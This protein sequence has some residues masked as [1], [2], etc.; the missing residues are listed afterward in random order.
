MSK[1]PL[2]SQF[3]A[4]R[5]GKDTT[6]WKL[7]LIC[8]SDDQRKGPLVLQPR[9]DTYKKVLDMVQERARFKDGNYVIVQERLKGIKQDTLREEKALWHRSC[10]SNAT[11][12]DQ[13]HRA[14]DR[15]EH[16]LSTGSFPAKIRGKKRGSSEMDEPGPSTYGQSAPFTRSSTVPLEKGLCFFCQE[17]NVEQLFK[18]CT[19]NAGK[20]LKSA[21]DKSQNAALV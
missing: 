20:D 9:L 3:G 18:L 6:N 7:C 13:I 14:R 8:Q 19:E 12:N 16:A 5:Q 1:I 11:N 21:I 10:Y 15:H 4:E 17:D 2:L